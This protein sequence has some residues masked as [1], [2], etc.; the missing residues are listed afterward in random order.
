[1]QNDPSETTNIQHLHPKVVVDMKKLLAGY[2]MVGR[3]NPGP[4]VSNDPSTRWRQIEILED[5]LLKKS[6]S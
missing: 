5:Y 1:M 6:E 3:S 2:I 4:R